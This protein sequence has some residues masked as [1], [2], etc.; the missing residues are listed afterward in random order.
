M[1]SMPTKY[2]PKPVPAPVYFVDPAT[3]DV[4]ALDLASVTFPKTKEP[5]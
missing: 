4:L 2:L 5:K 1:V 3:G